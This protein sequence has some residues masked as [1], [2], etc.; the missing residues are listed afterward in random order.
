MCWIVVG[1]IW[2]FVYRYGVSL[3]LIFGCQG[4]NAT[5]HNTFILRQADCN[6]RW[7]S[8]SFLLS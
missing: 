7:R 4:G 1:L 2:S 6:T 3:F 5:Q 8:G